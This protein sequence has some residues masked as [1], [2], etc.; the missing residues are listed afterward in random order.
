[1]ALQAIVEHAAD[2]QQ[3]F[4]GRR[5]GAGNA[6][7]LGSDLPNGFDDARPLTCAATWPANLTSGSYPLCGMM[8]FAMSIPTFDEW[9]A[10]R[11]APDVGDFCWDDDLSAGEVTIYLT[12]LFEHPSVLLDRFS[13]ENINKGLWSS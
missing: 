7:T 2:S 6:S 10:Y 1:M 11:F 4:A 5:V 12:Q 3:A 9:L 8:W 13:P